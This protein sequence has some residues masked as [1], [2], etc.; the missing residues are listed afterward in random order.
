MFVPINI[1]PS[2]FQPTQV[3]PAAPCPH[4]APEL[5]KRGNPR[6]LAEQRVR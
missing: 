5:G 2:R 4:A 1:L 3:A 6:T